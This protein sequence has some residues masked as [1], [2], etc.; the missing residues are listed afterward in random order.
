MGH[1]WYFNARLKSVNQRRLAE[2]LNYVLSEA[3]R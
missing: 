2:A 1:G 3:Q